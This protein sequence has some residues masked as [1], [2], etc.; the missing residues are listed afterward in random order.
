M[1]GCKANQA[2]RMAFCRH[3]WSA[4]RPR[5]IWFVPAVMG[6]SAAYWSAGVHSCPLQ[7]CARPALCAESESV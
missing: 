3:W 1:Q 2:G 6:V 5:V 4:W 7:P